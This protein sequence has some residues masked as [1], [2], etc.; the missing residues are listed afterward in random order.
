MTIDHDSFTLERR[1]AACPSHVFAC[2]ADPARKRRWFVDGDG[3]EW[4]TERY[5]LDFRVGGTEEGSFV[6]TSGPGAGRHENMT[7][8]LDIVPDERIAF[9]YTMAVDGRI[10]SASL[11]TVTFADAGGGTLLRF[12]EQGAFFGPSD[13][14]AGR[15]AGWEHILDNFATFMTRET[16]NA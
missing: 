7:H 3:P 15:R 6:L 4:E 8:F 16:A 1:I 14:A 13:G 2:W 9:A 10:H 5:A 11:A 12:T